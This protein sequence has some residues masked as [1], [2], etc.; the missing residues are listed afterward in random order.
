MTDEIAELVDWQLAQ[1][2]PVDIIVSVCRVCRTQWNDS[3]VVACPEC[4]ERQ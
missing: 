3:S 2:R 1:R 4:G